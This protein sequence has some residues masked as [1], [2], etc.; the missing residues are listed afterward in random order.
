M[1]S[2]RAIGTDVFVVDGDEVSSQLSRAVGEFMRRGQNAQ[3][4]VDAE[5]ARAKQAA[6]KVAPARPKKPRRSKGSAG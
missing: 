1:K 3:V 4:A 6:E 2:P 5:I